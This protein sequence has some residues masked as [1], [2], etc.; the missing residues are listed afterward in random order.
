MSHECPSLT[1]SVE[2]GQGSSHLQQTKTVFDGLLGEKWRKQTADLFAHKQ[3]LDD[4]CNNFAE[5]AD[6]ERYVGPKYEDKTNTI[7]MV[8]QQ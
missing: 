8:A 1:L 3:R 7:Y 4:E 5:K 6:S 2:S